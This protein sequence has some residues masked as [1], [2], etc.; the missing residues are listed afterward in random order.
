VAAGS[1]VLHRVFSVVN[2]RLVALLRSP[3]GGRLLG[4]HLTV[5]SYTGRRSGRRISTPVG[6]RRSADGVTIPVGMA[7][8]KRWWR[9]FTGEG[10]PLSL[11]LD[12][13]ERPGHGV[14]RRDERG[15]V[16][17]SVRLDRPD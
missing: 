13:V 1:Q 15:R 14:A 6:Y 3:R 9:N 5:V 11:H 16:S 8:S 10:A 4:G 2:P 7:Q 17:V 12:G